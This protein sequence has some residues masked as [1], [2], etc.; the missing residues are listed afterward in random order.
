MQPTQTLAVISIKTHKT[1]EHDNESINKKKCL[2][3]DAD[4]IIIIRPV[5]LFLNRF[6]SF[7]S[8]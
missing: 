2:L 8:F 7:H 6:P 5:T 1:N 4:Y 3:I